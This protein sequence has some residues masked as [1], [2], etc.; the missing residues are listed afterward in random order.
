MIPIRDSQRTVFQNV[1]EKLSE[2]FVFRSLFQVSSSVLQFLLRILYN[3]IFEAYE[4]L[5]KTPAS[6]YLKINLSK[7][8]LFYTKYQA[9]KERYLF[10]LFLN[11]FRNEC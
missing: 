10:S 8:T 1:E 6:Q 9:V 4:E 5:L 3:S 11:F 2:T 7:I